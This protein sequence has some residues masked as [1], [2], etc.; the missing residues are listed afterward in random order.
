[1]DVLC[2]LCLHLSGDM[3]VKTVSV[4]HYSTF[5]D[6]ILGKNDH[7]VCLIIT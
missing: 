1:M 2:C 6:S 5:K 3:Q 4:L 7:F